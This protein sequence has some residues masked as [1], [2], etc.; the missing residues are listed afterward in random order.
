MGATLRLTHPYGGHEDLLLL[1]GSHRIG[2]GPH[3]EV[4][5][6]TAKLEEEQ[7]VLEWAGVPELPE[8]HSLHAD[9][10]VRI[11]GTVV[12]GRQVLPREATVEIEG[13]RLQMI[14]PDD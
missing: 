11:D 8:L 3:C 4:R 5:L 10:R 9:E 2:S 6:P 12:E 14:Y 1:P 13:Y 7:A